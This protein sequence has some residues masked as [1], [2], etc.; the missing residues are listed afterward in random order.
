VDG[1]WRDI[2]D[3]GDEDL[4]Q[5]PILTGCQNGVSGS[6]LQ[7]LMVAAQRKSIWEKRHTPD[8]FRLEGICRR[9][10]RSRRWPSHPHNRWAWPGLGRARCVC[11]GLVP[12]LRLIFWLHGSSGEI[13]FLP[14]FPKFLL[15]VGFFCTKT[16]HQ[17]N[18]A[19]N[20]ISLC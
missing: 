19:E 6:E 5:I 11:G 7:F 17:S 2:G 20:S 14:I 1:R 9:K 18:S 16:R 13:G 10:E 4:L 3:N 15:K 12:S 8:I